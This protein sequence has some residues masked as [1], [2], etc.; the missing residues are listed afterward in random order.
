VKLQYIPSGVGGGATVKGFLPF[1]VAKLDMGAPTNGKRKFMAKEW[2]DL[3]MRIL[4]CSPEILAWRKKLAIVS[5]LT[6]LG[7]SNVNIMELDLGKV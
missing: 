5:R 2:V 1:Q 3:L 6:H 7:K 4:G